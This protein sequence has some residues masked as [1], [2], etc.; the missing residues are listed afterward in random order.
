MPAASA[1]EAKQQRTKAQAKYFLS[2]KPPPK[3]QPRELISPPTIA[4]CRVFDCPKP[5]SEVGQM[6]KSGRATRQSALPSRSDIISRAYQVRKVPTRDIL[7]EV[8]TQFGLY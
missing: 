5:M 6:R 1:G 7:L 2:T 4:L 3:I 8:S